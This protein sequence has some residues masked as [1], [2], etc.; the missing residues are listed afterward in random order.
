LKCTEIAAA[1]VPPQAT[2]GELTTIQILMMYVV[3]NEENGFEILSLLVELVGLFGCV[4]DFT[5]NNP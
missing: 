5:G 3:G 2:L 1:G 4:S